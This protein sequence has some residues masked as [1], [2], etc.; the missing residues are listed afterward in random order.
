M[1]CWRDDCSAIMLAVSF[2]SPDMLLVRIGFHTVSVL[3]VHASKSS[4]ASMYN[5]MSM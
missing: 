5:K 4:Q 1:M 2:V 3:L